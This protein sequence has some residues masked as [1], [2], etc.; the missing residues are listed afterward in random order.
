MLFTTVSLTYLLTGTAGYQSS[1]GPASINQASIIH[2][3]D[4][5]GTRPETK[6]FATSHL[7]KSI[8]KVTEQTL[9]FKSLLYMLRV[10]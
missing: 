4:G 8:T 5:P 1:S 6:Q 3:Q 7:P 10:N 9:P 2:N